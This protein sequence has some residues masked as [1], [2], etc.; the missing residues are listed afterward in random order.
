MQKGVNLKIEVEK[1]VI[2]EEEEGKT[3]SYMTVLDEISAEFKCESM[4]L[5][6]DN[7]EEYLDHIRECYFVLFPEHKEKHT[8]VKDCENCRY[9]EG[10]TTGL[11]CTINC[12]LV[13]H[14]HTCEQFVYS[15]S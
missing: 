2:V 4:Y 13:K 3:M 5:D 11:F 8:K 10:T 9:S 14:E 6:Y 1:V 12:K 15:E 7:L